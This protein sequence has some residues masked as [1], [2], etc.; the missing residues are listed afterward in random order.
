MSVK[1]R[2]ELERRIVKQ[3]VDDLLA[4]GFELFIDHDGDDDEMPVLNSDEATLD[5]IFACDEEHMYVREKGVAGNFGW[6]YFVYG[7][8]GWDV[9]SD[10][11]VNLEEHLKKVN[12]LA[13]QYA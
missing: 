6:I 11:T 4:A 10:Y 8:D 13:D 12:A 1:L 2:R 3:A 5:E 9:I 7:N